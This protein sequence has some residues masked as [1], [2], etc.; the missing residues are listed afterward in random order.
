MP[1]P[2]PGASGFWYFSAEA[3]APPVTANLTVP[4]RREILLGDEHRPGR[5]RVRLFLSGSAPARAEILSGQ[6]PDLF[7]ETELLLTVVAR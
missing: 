3:G 2:R 1:S 6:A 7:A 5:Y 4:L